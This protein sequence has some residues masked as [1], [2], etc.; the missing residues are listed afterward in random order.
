LARLFQRSPAIT[1]RS[2]LLDI[3]DF[4]SPSASAEDVVSQVCRGR[5]AKQDIDGYLATTS[6]FPDIEYNGAVTVFRV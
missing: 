5:S 1:G 2:I 3:C 6:I 4:F